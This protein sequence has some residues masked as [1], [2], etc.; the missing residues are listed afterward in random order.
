VFQGGTSVEANWTLPSDFTLTS[1]SSYRFWNFTPRNDDGLNVPASYNAGVSVETSSGPR[2]SAW[3]PGGF[4]DY[5]LGAYYF[6]N[7][8]DNKSFAYYGPRPISGT[9]RPPAPWPTSAASATGTSHRQFALFAQGTW[10]LTERLDFTAGVRGT[11]EEKAPGSPATIPSAVRRSRCGRYGPTAGP[12][13]VPMIPVTSTNTAPALPGCSAR[14]IASTKT[15]WATRRCPMAKSPAGQP[16]SGVRTDGR[17]RLLLVGTERANNAELG[18]KSTLWDRRLQLN[19][20]LFWTQV[21]GYQTNAYDQ[22][23]RVQYLTNAG[24]VRSR[25]VEGGKHRC[26]SGA[27]IEPQRL[28]QRRE[29]PVT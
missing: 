14:A 16:G 25:G 3:R 1:V 23:N 6:G 15:C 10:H 17:G 9:A 21:N 18:F 26:R 20:N 7:S 22:D 5:V 19:A 28:V 11:Y 2:N 13:A 27:D 8:L 29:L 4:F 24:S 12:H